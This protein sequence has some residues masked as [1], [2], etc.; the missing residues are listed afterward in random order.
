MRRRRWAAVAASA[1]VLASA[2]FLAAPSHA[3]ERGTA[4]VTVW[5]QSQE[6]LA[7]RQLANQSV[8]M[9]AHL[10]QGGHAVRFRVQNTFGTEPLRIDRATVGV[11]A[12]G[13]EVVDPRPAT[14]AGNSAVPIPP[15]GDVWSDPVRLTTRPDS[16]IAISLHVSGTAVPGQHNSAFREN[17]LSPAGSGD[18]T[19][20]RSGSSYTEKTTSTYFVSAVDVQNP[21]L[22]GTIVP[23]GSSVVDGTGSTD[24]GPGC[25]EL[26]T[27]R[28]WTDELAR[29]IVREAPA[30]R[31]Y[32][33][34]NAGVAGTTSSAACPSIPGGARGLDALARLERDVLE[35]HGVSAVIY[36]YGTNDLAFGC[37]DEQ[38][39]DSY[40]E[41]FR[42][43]RVAGVKVYVTPITPR[44]S[45]TEQ[46]NRYRHE[47]GTFVK[48]WNNCTDT[49]DGV[50]DFDQVLKDPV[51]PNQ[52]NPA[53]DSDGI[54]ANIAGQKAIADFISIP[55]ITGGGR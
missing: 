49:C 6:R 43:L 31:Q 34:A 11:S 38:I 21:K 40:R 15:G 52:L 18:V 42:R 9:I 53:Y 24:C 2:A 17:Y 47:V 55:L 23:F 27:N 39:L 13:A 4:W 5:A 26:G 30:T 12:G 46:Q 1:V 25:T 10:S 50:L 20:E 37:T 51:Q 45:Y 35:L 16:D 22:R 7:G 54:H 44:A 3:G 8:R 36:Y 28:R 48:R 29:R 19:S 14:F 41:V 32:A 33:V